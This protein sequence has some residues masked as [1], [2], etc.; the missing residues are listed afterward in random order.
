MRCDQ[1]RQHGIDWRSPP[2]SRDTKQ[3]ISPNGMG[4]DKAAQLPCIAS[5][6][7]VKAETCWQGKQAAQQRHTNSP[8]HISFGQS[9]IKPAAKHRTQSC[10]RTAQQTHD[11]SCTLKCHAMGAD[12]KCGCPNANAVACEAHQ[13]SGKRDAHEDLGSPQAFENIDQ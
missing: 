5:R 11:R 4:N 9:V 10:S 1:F 8:A 12:Q 2:N 7:E 6:Q 3:Q 13:Q